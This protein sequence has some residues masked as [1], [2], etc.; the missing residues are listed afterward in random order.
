M[1]AM[2]SREALDNRAL[3]FGRDGRH[4]LDDQAAGV[5]EQFASLSD[6]EFG[7][8][9]ASVQWLDELLQKQHF[10][11]HTIDEMYIVATNLGPFLG[12]ALCAAGAGRWGWDGARAMWGVAL[13]DGSFADPFEA[14]WEHLLKG[15]GAGVG[16]LAFFQRTVRQLQ[17]S[18]AARV[19]Q[20]VQRAEDSAFG[21]ATDVDISCEVLRALLQEGGAGNLHVLCG[22]PV[23]AAA[24]FSFVSPDRLKTCATHLLRWLGE[25]PGDLERAE[26]H[27][28]DRWVFRTGRDMLGL[29]QR[30]GVLSIA[31]SVGTAAAKVTLAGAPQAM[32]SAEKIEIATRTRL[33]QFRVPGEAQL[34]LGRVLSASQSKLRL[35]CDSDGRHFRIPVQAIEFKGTQP[36]QDAVEALRG[37]HGSAHE[38]LA[39]IAVAGFDPDGEPELRVMPDDSLEVLF[40]FMPPSWAEDAAPFDTFER[41][42]ERAV[43]VPVIREDRELFRLPQVGA[44][45]VSALL[46]FLQGHRAGVRDPAS[47][48]VCAGPQAQGAGEHPL[49]AR[50]RAAVEEAAGMPWEGR[51]G[52]ARACIRILEA[53]VPDA[54][55][56]VD[57]LR[58]CFGSPVDFRSLCECIPPARL[59]TMCQLFQSWRDKGQP[60]L[61]AQEMGFV[62]DVTY[63][64][65][66]TLL[67][68]LIEDGVLAFAPVMLNGRLRFRAV[69]PGA[70]SVLGRGQQRAAVRRAHLV[71]FRLRGQSQVRI[72]RVLNTFDDQAVQLRCDATGESF[73]VPYEA[74][75]FDGAELAREAIDAAARAHPPGVPLGEMRLSGFDEAGE[76]LIRFQR[77]G[78]FLILFQAMP[79]SWHRGPEEF[80]PIERRMAERIGI[81]IERPR[82]ALMM[83]P[84]PQPGQLWA[85]VDFLQNYHKIGAAFTPA[86]W[87]DDDL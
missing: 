22:R 57:A 62:K 4:A 40:N 9:A 37:A 79:P 73:R 61:L 31:P 47:R 51:C 35:R 52:D 53:L 10:K 72:G 46:E 28:D 29:L 14:V 85:I 66:H 76:P 60:G 48:P 23:T 3:S 16:V 58:A 27:Q 36:A 24:L 83:V 32:T 87:Q 5:V 74:V 75:L 78:S 7:F 82:P 39:V 84:T 38:P 6:I 64:Q 71:Q 20:E 2:P 65:A 30:D 13:A 43:G 15:R 8:N 70:L 33:L 63:W 34:L 50:V 56:D 69:L 21:P 26:L 1:P 77:N 49:R 25:Q 44:G 54:D 11:S 86:G 55:A 18:L 45:G 17:D 67:D 80:E 68:V 42:I 81:A 12:H 59:K 41:L 19:R